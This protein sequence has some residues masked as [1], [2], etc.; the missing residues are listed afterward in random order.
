MKKNIQHGFSA[1]AVLLIVVLLAIISATGWYVISANS[2]TNN[3]LNNVD[4]NSNIKV[5]LPSKKQTSASSQKITSP[6]P[7]EGV[8]AKIDNLLNKG[9]YLKLNEYMTDKISL[10]VQS[11]D[12]SPDMSKDDAAKR[13]DNYLTKSQTS[14]GAE[15]PWDFSEQNASRNKIIK[16]STCCFADFKAQGHIG[17]SKDGW[18]VAYNL[19]SNSKLESFY[20]SV[21]AELLY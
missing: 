21:S 1:V 8:A 4:N 15:L 19:N 6:D 11:T 16:S 2:K 13:I 17:I 20:I 10:V 5:N 9:E 3:S 7:A 18:V 14:N 12:N